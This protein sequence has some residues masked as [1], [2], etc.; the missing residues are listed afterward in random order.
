MFFVC[1]PLDKLR[2]ETSVFPPICLILQPNLRITTFFL[3]FVLILLKS[4]FFS[5]VNSTCGGN[6][7]A[8]FLAVSKHLNFQV[9]SLVCSQLDIAPPFPKPVMTLLTICPWPTLADVPPQEMGD[10]LPG[11]SSPECI[12][13]YAPSFSDWRRTSRCRRFR[14][15]GLSS[16]KKAQPLPSLEELVWIRL[17]CGAPPDPSSIR[18]QSHVP[19]ESSCGF[20]S[21]CSVLRIGHLRSVLDWSPV[22]LL[23]ILLLGWCS[24][25]LL[26]FCILH[27]KL[28]S[29][30]GV[31]LPA[32]PPPL[33]RILPAPFLSLEWP[34][35][36]HD[37][38]LLR[39]HGEV[40]CSARPPSCLW[41]REDSS[42]CPDN[43]I[44]ALALGWNLGLW[45]PLGAIISIGK[46][47]AS[48][49]TSPCF[50]AASPPEILTLSCN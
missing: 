25:N 48:G 45:I 44:W 7:G 43:S 41:P 30:D 29:R 18:V 10:D 46:L 17:Y 49:Y 36:G 26:G 11:W 19:P 5:I 42:V 8:Q 21:F 2:L 35:L 28:R 24:A 16:L 39:F 14:L 31:S 32:L 40:W 15:D 9:E 4:Q 20:L 22:T 3:S 1:H 47:P 50:S 12:S 27:L 23:H 38:Q 34:P 37:S 13:A 6:Q 33:L